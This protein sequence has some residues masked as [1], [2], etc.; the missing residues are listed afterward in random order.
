MFKN[1]ETLKYVNYMSYVNYV[2]RVNYMSCASYVNYACRLYD[3]YDSGVKWTSLGQ[4]F[5]NPKMQILT[6]IYLLFLY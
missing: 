4:I 5:Q 2:S 3:L 1:F 6:P